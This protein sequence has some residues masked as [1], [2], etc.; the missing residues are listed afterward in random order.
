M[1]KSVIIVSGFPF[2]FKLDFF[3]NPKEKKI[4]ITAVFFLLLLF[5]FVFVLLKLLQKTILYQ[6]GGM[7]SFSVSRS[8]PIGTT[9]VLRMLQDLI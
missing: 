9:L 3:K 7:T 2:F 6:G 8:S 4:I 5:C 1:M